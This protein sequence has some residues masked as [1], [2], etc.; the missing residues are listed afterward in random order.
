MNAPEMCQHCPV[1]VQGGDDG[2]AAHLRVVHPELRAPDGRQTTPPVA[3]PVG[4]VPPTSIRQPRRYRPPAGYADVAART[5]RG[6]A[7]RARAARG[8]AAASAALA[9]ARNR[10]EPNGSDAPA[11]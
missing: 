4:S 2:M 11:R 8:R 9:A 5:L 1:I 6:E 10:S 3:P 7:A